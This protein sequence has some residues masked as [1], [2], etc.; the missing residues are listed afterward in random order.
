MKLKDKDFN[1][2]EKSWINVIDDNCNISEISLKEVIVNA[3]KYRALSGEI[4]AQDVAIMRLILAVLHTVF[5]RVDENGNE[6]PLDNNK[7]KA[8][9]R[10]KALWSKGSFSG[11]AISDYFDKWRERF[12]LFH[13]E[14]PFYQIPK[15]DMLK[16]ISGQSEIYLSKLN[17][18]ISQ[19]NNKKNIFTLYSGKD[20]DSMSY[21]Q[22]ARW[23][24]FTQAYDD[25]AFKPQGANSHSAS[26]GWLGQLGLI[27]LV[28]DSL[29]ETLMLNLVLINNS[30]VESS[31]KPIWEKDAICCDERVPIV[32][33]DNLA[34]LYTIQSRRIHLFR[35]EDEITHF[36]ILAGD[37]VS[38]NNAF[39]EPMTA[40]KNEKKPDLGF[41]P[42][43]HD[44]P[45]QMWREFTALY[46]KDGNE[47]AG[48]ISWYKNILLPAKVIR[49]N[50]MMKTAIV[51][52]QYD[53]S[54]THKF[55][56]FY[57]DSLA[58]HSDLLSELGADWRDIIET[59]LEKCSKAAVELSKFGQG[60]Y[61]ASGWKNKDKDKRYKEEIPRTVKSNLYFHL[62][63][64][65]RKWLRTIDP[66]CVDEKK[67]YS[68][69]KEWQQ[70]AKRIA[71][72]LANDLFAE[73][74]EKAILG[75]KIKKEYF[76]APRSMNIFI[77]E[78][79]KIYP[80]E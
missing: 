47:C 24:V 68:K 20:F 23:L 15:N 32:F 43:E 61:V 48:I 36:H 70:T 71:Y 11:K 72:N 76:A 9:E 35:N 59:E 60:L 27:Y 17:G 30:H 51:A 44:S 77:S 5:S 12:G 37:L 14:R 74:S 6:I 78:L 4:P 31:Q 55:V 29:F 66:E 45:K 26:V 79:N 8:L 67:K 53:K 75:H 18:E 33:P 57:F 80:K 52:L 50:Q 42:L 64:P 34:E 62:D 63:L 25:V 7:K 58:M 19:S 46:H 22:A 56:N 41:T 10:W 54:S 69:Q 1:L 13:P 16:R 21:A 39:E 38:S 40:W 3:H 73:T 28:G 49:K 65:F 2:I